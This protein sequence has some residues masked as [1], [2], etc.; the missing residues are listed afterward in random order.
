MTSGSFASVPIDS[1]TVNREERQRRVLDDAYINSLA[2]SISKRGLIHPPVIDRN[3]T[4]V[5]GECRLEA[6]R[7]LGW[8][9]IPIQYIDELDST[10][11]RAVELEENVRRKNLEWKEE[12]LA[13]KEYHDLRRAEAPEWN[14]EN[15]ST[16]LGYSVRRIEELIQVASEIMNGNSRVMAAPK[17]S[18]A[19][20]IVRRANERAANS[21]SVALTEAFGV[22][23]AKEPESI[24][25]A[26]FREWAKTY[27]GPKFNFIHCDFPYG[28]GADKFVQGSADIHGG[29][30]DRPDN[31][32]NLIHCL[33]D[34]LDRL[35][36][37]S[38]HIMFWFSMHFYRETIDTIER[39]SNFTLDRF[40]L[41]WIKSDNIGIIPDPERGPRRIYE[42]AFFG[43]RG[44]RRITSPVSNAFSHPSQRD[45]HMSIKPDGMLRHFFKMFVDGSTVFLDPTCGSGSSVRMAKEAGAKA[46]LGLEINSD[47]ADRARLQ[48]KLAGQAK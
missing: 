22:P 7:R 8:T 10:A 32:F 45:D 34:N 9:S 27:S 48:M 16:E 33:C 23:P 41:V 13:V 28:I 19:T 15:T 14:K 40:P 25:T 29:Y 2:D 26:D 3:G 20:G 12:C 44:D 17:M 35:G 1:I 18:T 21:A 4:L 24:L 5:V 38:C 42:T 30:D 39:H 36:N 47:F 6:T 37:E 46:A 11:L 43:S 31:Y